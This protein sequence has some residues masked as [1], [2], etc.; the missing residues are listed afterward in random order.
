MIPA[1][2]DSPQSLL[3]FRTP[4]LSHPIPSGVDGGESRPV[5]ISNERETLTYQ[6]M[7]SNGLMQACSL[8]LFWE[9]E[10]G[11]CRRNPATCFEVE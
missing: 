3:I 9:R 2:G 1:S 5:R 10:K 8:F 11:L 7:A 6:E 4:S